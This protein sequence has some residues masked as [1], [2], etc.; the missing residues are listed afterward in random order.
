MSEKESKTVRVPAFD[1]DESKYQKWRI[2]FRGCAKLAG[3][4]KVIGTEP[5]L[6]LPE[7]QNEVDELSRNNEET[8]KKRK[9]ASISNLAMASLTLVFTSDE[10]LDIIM[11]AQ[12][13]E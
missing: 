7:I 12:T 3:L 4:T 5:N 9:A 10:L 1:G 2:R 6:D 13:K 11:E 8:K